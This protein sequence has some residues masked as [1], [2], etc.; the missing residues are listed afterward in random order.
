[1]SP[2]WFESQASRDADRPTGEEGSLLRDSALRSLSPKDEL[3][4][5]SPAGASLLIYIAEN[6]DRT[7][8]S[9]DASVNEVCPV[10]I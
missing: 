3:Q 9:P 8:V 7:R 4:V 2:K 1:M 6:L 10:E 5:C